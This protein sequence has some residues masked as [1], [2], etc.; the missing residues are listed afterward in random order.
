MFGDELIIGS[1]RAQVEHLKQIL[2]QIEDDQRWKEHSVYYAKEMYDVEKNLRK[3]RKF[4]FEP[5][6]KR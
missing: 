3:I 2:A 6:N 1:V 5:I 4:D